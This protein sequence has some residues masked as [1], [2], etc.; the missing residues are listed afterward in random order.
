MV[1]VFTTKTALVLYTSKNGFEEFPRG[2]WHTVEAEALRALGEESLERITK[3]GKRTTKKGPA[4]ERASPR[5]N[6]QRTM[7]NGK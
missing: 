1:R 5:P 4:P 6:R 3:Q 2:D 7:H